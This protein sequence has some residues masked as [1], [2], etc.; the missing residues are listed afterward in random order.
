[1][2]GAQKKGR[3]PERGYLRIGWF[4]VSGWLAN[5]R[6]PNI[7]GSHDGRDLSPLEIQRRAAEVGASW[8]E[9]ERRS[10]L[11]YRPRQAELQPIRLARLIDQ[12]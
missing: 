1:M 9:R 5:E 4:V 6:P 11:S 8:T 7:D 12:R 10:R 2:H 3:Y